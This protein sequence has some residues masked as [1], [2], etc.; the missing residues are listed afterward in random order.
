MKRD[1][2]V[3]FYVSDKVHKFTGFK[4][5]DTTGEDVESD[6]YLRVKL[7]ELEGLYDILFECLKKLGKEEGFNYLRNFETVS[8]LS[9]GSKQKALSTALEKV[10]A[11]PASGLQS[12]V[13]KGQ[14]PLEGSHQDPFSC[15]IK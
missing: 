13:K 6:T 11:D 3:T 1:F 14:I 2:F 15:G 12:P 4:S 9:E 8:E 10:L 7:G 5:T